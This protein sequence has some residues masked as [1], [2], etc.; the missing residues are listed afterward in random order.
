LQLLIKFIISLLCFCSSIT[1]LYADQI[2]VKPELKNS[3][4]VPSIS[5]VNINN[6]GLPGLLTIPDA[7]NLPDGEIIFYNNFHRGLARNG[8]T[9]QVAPNIGISFRYSGHGR[10][11]FEASGRSNHDRSF[12]INFKLLNESVYKPSVSIGLRDFIG[13]GWYSSEYVVATKNVGPISATA[14][15][16]FGRLAGGNKFSNPLSAIKSSFGKRDTNSV[17]KGGTL[18]TINW[19]QGPASP[20]FGLKYDYNTKTSFIAEYSP[21]LME[22]E[23]RYVDIKS[24]VNVGV[25]HNLN[26]LISL[27]AQY[28]HGSTIALGAN[29]QLNPKRSVVRDN[30][31][32]APLPLRNRDNINP[33]ISKTDISA[34]KKLLEADE[35]LINELQLKPNHIKI[36][37]ENKKYR[38]TAQALGR[39]SIILQR[40]TSDQTKYADIIILT[41]QYPTAS[42]RV[43]LQKLN[44]YQKGLQRLSDFEEIVLPQSSPASIKY[45]EIGI[46]KF[47]SAVSPY[48]D[49]RL[50]DPIQP[51]RAE[52]GLKAGFSYKL[53]QNFSIYGAMKKSLI[54][55]FDEIIRYSDSVLP[56][57]HSDFA[58]YDKSGQRGHIDHLKFLHISKI[59]ENIHSLISAGFLEPMYAGISGELLHKFPNS[60]LAFGVDLNAVQMREYDMM[61]GLRDYKTITSH[62]NFYYDAGRSFDLE[63]NIGRYLAKDFGVTTK[64]SRRF[65]NGWSV[66]AYATFTDVPFDTFGEGSFDKGFYI[67]IPLDWSSGLASKSTRSVPIKMITR[68]GGAILSSSKSLHRFIRK[69]KQSEI[70]REYGRFLK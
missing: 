66:G 10:N 3:P 19:F 39:I 44:N 15:I 54:S 22:R 25:S 23:K 28:L 7:T 29:L 33:L 32:K 70:K 35:F 26:N 55:D 37:V 18:G 1:S 47:K 36:E 40:L 27:N 45:S 34:I 42:Y 58:I 65:G 51:I 49:Y 68:D 52:L 21:D 59:S 2:T 12:D 17:G 61:F 4:I 8:F 57:V 53:P 5:P 6:F 13:T 9:F 67:N 56:H 11:S 31:H 30:F 60:N 41:E 43:N 16:G 24:P 69:S 46:Q 14:G 48:F 64:L 63:M 62:L 38:S 50:F 20:F